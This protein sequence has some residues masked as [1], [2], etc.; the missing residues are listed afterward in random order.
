MDELAQARNPIDTFRLYWAGKGRLSGAYWKYGVAGTLGIYFF[1]M[2]GS[3]MLLPVALREHQS[4]L[5]SPIF[6][7][8]LLAVYMLLAY[9]VV[10]W[11]LIW[12]NA[13][14]V[15]NPIWGHLAKVAVVGST[16]LLL[17]HAV[18]AI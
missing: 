9:Q 11:A 5:E 18:G 12:R 13:R 16:V 3:L 6:Q 17:V 15:K 1:A 7:A 10:V 4:V 2:I 8:Y 14:N